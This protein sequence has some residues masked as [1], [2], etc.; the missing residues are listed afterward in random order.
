MLAQRGE[1]DAEKN[2]EEDDLQDVA[3]REGVDDARGHDVRE[4]V[5]EAH[6][7]PL[8]RVL[9]D[10]AA[11]HGRH[12]QAGARLGDVHDDEPDRERERRH[13]LEV[14]ERLEADGADLLQVVHV[15]DAE[16]DREED[17]RPD[18]HPDERDER[19]AQ[20]SHRTRGIRRD[21]AERHS[22]RDRDENAKGQVFE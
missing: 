5:A 4:E 17:D 11:S 21:D 1:R 2:R 16:R 10:V 7:L 13:D 8:R 14:D 12:V 22:D 3:F 15:G 18:H 20:R 19:V 6:R 9:R